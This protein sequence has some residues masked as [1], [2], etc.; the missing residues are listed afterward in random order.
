MAGAP[1][2]YM[3]TTDAC[4]DHEAIRRIY[5]LFDE[6]AKA[7]KLHRPIILDGSMEVR[8]LKHPLGGILRCDSCGMLY[9]REVEAKAGQSNPR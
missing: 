7:P 4:L 5:D 3:L 6:M 8:E 1:F 2:A 9:E